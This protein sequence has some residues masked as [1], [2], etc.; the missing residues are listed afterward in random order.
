MRPP[1]GGR[2]PSRGIPPP[3]PREGA[4]TAG[5]APAGPA[6][7]PRPGS[8]PAQPSPYGPP[9]PS[10]ICLQLEQRLVVETQG[11]GQGREPLPKIETDMRDL[12]R[13]MRSATIQ[14][15]RSEC[16]D[17][18]LFSK[19]L[20]RTPRCRQLNDDVENARQRLGRPRP[21]APADHGHRRPLV[22]GRHHPRAG[23]QRLRPAVRAGG[24]QAR[25]LQQSLRPAV[26]RRRGERRIRAGPP[27]S[28]ATCRSPPIARCV[29]VC[30]TATISPS[31]SRRCPTTSSATRRCASRSAQRPPSST[32]TR[33]PAAR[34]SRW[35]RSSSQQ[36]Y[37]SLKSAFRYRKEFVQGCSCK[38]AEYKP[39][40]EKKAEAPPA[41]FTGTGRAAGRQAR[42][43]AGRRQAGGR[44][45]TTRAGR[46][47]VERRSSWC[48]CQRARGEYG[49]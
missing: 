25:C 9:R 46:S 10:N 3:V 49:V 36:P 8:P 23:P 11:S 32:T 15:D 16:W 1:S 30:A 20:R 42:Q 45:R 4:A 29:C 18:F 47:N 22:P 14:L 43:L 40:P 31:A 41:T 21:P 34:S 38:Q 7:P 28:S 39:G 35:C 37:T 13:T 26:R 24:P 48:G 5:P 17:Q 27:T 2:G 6:P 12:E 33:T 44:P 19:T